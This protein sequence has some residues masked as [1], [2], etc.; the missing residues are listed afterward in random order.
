MRK[1][2]LKKEVK[3]HQEG[4]NVGD[5]ECVRDAES[6]RRVEREMKKRNEKNLKHGKQRWE[7]KGLGLSKVYGSESVRQK[8]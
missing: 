6:R 5:R 7:R 3:R 1:I 2:Y 4:R 8:Q